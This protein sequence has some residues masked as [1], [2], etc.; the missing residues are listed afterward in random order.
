MSNFF[1]TNNRNVLRIRI[2]KVGENFGRNLFV[3]NTSVGCD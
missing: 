2:R 3:V 1:D